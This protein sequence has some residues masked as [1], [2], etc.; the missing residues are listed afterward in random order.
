MQLRLIDVPVDGGELR[1]LQ[2]GTGKRVAV[3]VHGITAS[4]PLVFAASSRRTTSAAD[5]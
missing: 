5:R 1:V 3:A 2:W 4:A